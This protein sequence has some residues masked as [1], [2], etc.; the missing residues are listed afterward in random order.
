MSEWQ[1]VENMLTWPLSTGLF[2]AS[3]LAT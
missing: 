3:I 1:D 2:P